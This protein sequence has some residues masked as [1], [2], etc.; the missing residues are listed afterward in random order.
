MMSKNFIVDFKNDFKFL[1]EYGFVFSVDPCNPNRPCQKNNH[2]EI[3]LWIQTNSGIF[4]TTEI[5]YQIN[6]W[7][8]TINLEEEY[9]KIFKKTTLFKNKIKLF[10]DLFE[11]LVHSSGSFYNLRIDKNIS[12]SLK[13]EEV[14]DLNIFKNSE[15]VINLH[16]RAITNV[17]ELCLLII[18]FLIETLGW[19]IFYEFSKSYL[20]MNICNIVLFVCVMISEVLIYLLLR[21]SLH[22][23][24]SLSIIIYA[25]IP[26][27]L[28]F[29]FDRRFDY[30]V[31]M[32]FLGLMICSLLIHFVIYLFKKQS[33]YLLN[34]FIPVIYPLVI[35][36]IKTNILDEYLFLSELNIGKYILI[37]LIIGII[38]GSIVLI[39]SKKGNS[40]KET[41]LIAF[42]AFCCFFI[43]SFSVPFYT[44]QNINYAF[45]KS[46]PI[47]YEYTVV[48]KRIGRS[49]GRYSSNMYYL[50]IYVEGEKE[51]LKVNNRVY[52]DFE[53][54]ETIDL[55]MYEGFL[56]KT[57]F[58]YIEE[59]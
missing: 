6:G 39:A 28:Y 36:F 44:I 18:L 35:S 9:K 47:K 58:E 41:F 11:F 21:R 27:A 19:I 53:I 24:S 4:S 40:I 29:F 26:I 50:V 12:S 49:H 3:I 30:R 54:N 37:G 20:V 43:V 42:S 51:E 52:N 16:N 57:Y 14:T 25:F 1:E 45:D 15:G 10:K 46:T 59:N 23:V 8:Y 7:K 17:T 56:N 33:Y 22:I 38:A 13:N 2:G 31:E 34:G 5:Y 48:D 55:Y 32:I